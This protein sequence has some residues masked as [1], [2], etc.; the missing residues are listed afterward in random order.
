MGTSP[1]LPSELW[2]M[3]LTHSIS[4]PV[5]FDADVVENISPWY[6]D[7]PTVE[8]NNEKPY[9][10]AERNRSSMRRV[11]RSWND[12]LRQYDHRYVR[13]IDIA[14]GIVPA[15]HLKSAVRV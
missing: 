1:L 10:T 3:I 15:H 6:I 7:D 13:M 5:F 9:W 11:C 14:H 12:Y 4:V 8:W 2:Q